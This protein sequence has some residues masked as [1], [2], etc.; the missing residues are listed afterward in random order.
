MYCSTCGNELN[1]KAVI[2]PRCGC[3][4]KELT[5]TP[6]P[7]TQNVVQNEEIDER[8]NKFFP[9]FN[10]ISFVLCLL[11]FFTMFATTYLG[12]LESTHNYDGYVFLFYSNSLNDIF[13]FAM[14]CVF[15]TISS[16]IGIIGLSKTSL[17]HFSKIYSII[18][19]VINF[20]SFGL[21]LS[22]FLMIY[23]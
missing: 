9:H 15:I 23:C 17:K 18:S 21:L 12:Y 19:L 7:P 22:N 4:V 11:P 14:G 10:F 5:P 13:L 20:V 6:E 16:V 1:E 8:K 2:C 3:A